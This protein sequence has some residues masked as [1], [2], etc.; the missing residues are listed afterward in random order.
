MG[1]VRGTLPN[2]PAYAGKTC[3]TAV[4]LAS[5]WAQPRIRGEKGTG[6]RTPR[7][8][9]FNPTYA[10]KSDATHLNR[11]R[12]GKQPHM[13]GE[14]SAARVY[15]V[16]SIGSTPHARGKSL[17]ASAR[18]ATRGT[19]PHT[20]ERRPVFNSTLRADRNNPACAGRIAAPGSA[21]AV[22]REQPRVR[23]ETTITTDAG[24]RDWGTTPRTRGKSSEV[25]GAAEPHRNNP[26]YAGKRLRDQRVCSYTIEFSDNFAQP[27]RPAV[28]T[29]AA[30]R[31][32]HVL[33]VP[34][35][36]SPPRGTCL[37]R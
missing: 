27:T 7:R 32:Q 20:R 4:P 29:T 14:K 28:A 33:F 10:G 11:I 35:R 26:A 17:N 16:H 30:C 18:L 13:R 22:R 37:R 24:V 2:N 21:A 15:E 36:Q 34:V 1:P 3:Q 25:H 19:T 6:G 12:P 8:H 31:N 9:R 5:S 23:G